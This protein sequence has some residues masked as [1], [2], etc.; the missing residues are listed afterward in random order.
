MDAIG[1]VNFLL[2]LAIIAVGYLGYSKNKNQIYLYMTIAFSFF[3]V[4]NLLTALELAAQYTLPM[5]FLRVI[6]Y[7]SVLYGLY[8]G[9][10]KK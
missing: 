2:N 6:G 4:T 3:A 1:T 8:K 10:G 7:V 9:I 5:I